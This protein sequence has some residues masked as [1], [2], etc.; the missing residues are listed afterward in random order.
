MKK[1]SFFAFLVISS[2]AS[3]NTVNSIE[4]ISDKENLYR[5]SNTDS[6]LLY[7]VS[8]D[9]ENLYIRLNTSE[10]TSIAKILR[11][12]LT[13]Y[14][15]VKGKKRKDIFVHYPLAQNQQLSD[16]EIP[17]PGNNNIHTPQIEL[18]KLISQI[19]DIASY[20]NHKITEDFSVVMAD[21]D[22]KINI[23]A[24]TNTEITYSLSIPFTK[25]AKNGLA[26]LSNLS[27][28]IV[29][30]R[31]DSPASGGSGKSGGGQ[32]QS[33]AGMGSSGM[34]SGGGQGRGRGMGSGQAQGNMSAMTTPIKFWFKIDI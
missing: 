29:S 30:G 20:S 6:N 3:L 17:R 5:Y 16:N 2:C 1:I 21:S 31:F 26:D 4:D 24:K 13:I 12:G 7:Y 22:I 8:N 23:Q 25:I 27:V 19:S 32:G 15:D 10:T 28:G 11:T 14:F 34:H 9:A 33:G 18:T